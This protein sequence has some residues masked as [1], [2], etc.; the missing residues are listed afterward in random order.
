MS[1]AALGR[2]PSESTLSKRSV[3]LKKYFC[4]NRGLRAGRNNHAYGKRWFTDENTDVLSFSRP[5]GFRLGRK[6]P[7]E[8]TRSKQRVSRTGKKLSKDAVAKMQGE[9]NHMY[10]R[11]GDKAP[12]YGKVWF[13]NGS[14]N[15]FTFECP[16]GYYK[17]RTMAPRRPKV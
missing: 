6:S 9:N 1:N 5:S 4:K 15:S 7:S 14:K 11:T 17:G 16:E 12:S 13:T 10:G 3:S 8:E 2:N